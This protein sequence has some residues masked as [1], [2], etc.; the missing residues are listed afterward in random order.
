MALQIE[1]QVIRSSEFVYREIVRG[2]DF[3]ATWAKSRKETGLNTVSDDDVQ[4][5]YQLIT[6]FVEHEPKYERQHKSEF[7]NGADCWLI[8]HA[9][10]DNKGTV[11]TYE[12]ERE[13]GK[14]KVTSVCAR[15]TVGCI[16]IYKLQDELNFNPADYRR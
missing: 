11:V 13:Y 10:A 4:R 8:A 12:T 7:Y 14:I 16:D 1:T 2:N 15:L 5:Q 6:D 3:L 9:R